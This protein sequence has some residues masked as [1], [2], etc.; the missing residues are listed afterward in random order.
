M[1]H[2][3]AETLM[4]RFLSGDLDEEDHA[5][6]LHHLGV[7]EPCREM[8][9]AGLDWMDRLVFQLADAPPPDRVWQRLARQVRP[10]RTWRLATLWPLPLAAAALV[11]GLAV[12]R[13]WQATPA[14]PV[15]S[16]SGAMVLRLGG[17]DPRTVGQVMVSEVAHRITVSVDDLSSPPPGD[18]YEVWTIRGKG[19]QALG[20]LTLRSG[21]G[22]LTAR[23]QLGPGDEVVVCQESRAWAGHWM[24]P[25]VLTA[26]VPGS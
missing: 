19:A 17:L 11:M 6:Y 12:G 24:G 9:Q 16:P 23:G 10:K 1:A 22:F 5:R 7:C 8:T 15:A 21:H 3:E 14:R 26:S 20:I 18:L 2:C 25:A 4:L 13:H